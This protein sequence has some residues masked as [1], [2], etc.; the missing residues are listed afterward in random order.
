M[1]K[2][3]S[4]D[5]KYVVPS[6]GWRVEGHSVLIYRS[7]SKAKRIKEMSPDSIRLIL[8]ISFVDYLKNRPLKKGKH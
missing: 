8:L 1:D 7:I 6:A 3:K 5:Y 2:I 4:I